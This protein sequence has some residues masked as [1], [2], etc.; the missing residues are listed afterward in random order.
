MQ[1]TALVATRFLSLLPGV[2]S[3]KDDDSYSHNHI[4]ALKDK[5]KSMNYLFF[6]AILDIS[7]RSKTRG[8]APLIIDPP[9]LKL[10]Q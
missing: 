1:P 3:P 4:A 8:V 5:N 2:A 6:V 7:R 10:N 9:P